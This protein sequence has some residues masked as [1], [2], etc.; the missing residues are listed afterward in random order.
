MCVSGMICWKLRVEEAYGVLDPTI[1]A[2]LCELRILEVV[3]VNLYC[4]ILLKCGTSKQVSLAD[5]HMQE[6][7]PTMTLKRMFGSC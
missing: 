6:R 7:P 1:I 2:E 5:V 4:W 3:L